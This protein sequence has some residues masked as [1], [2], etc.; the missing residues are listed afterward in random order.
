ML[1]SRRNPTIENRQ[2]ANHP[3]ITHLRFYTASARTRQS[4]P[5]GS[6]VCLVLAG[7][8]SRPLRSDPAPKRTP[9]HTSVCSASSKAS[10]TSMPRY[11][12]VSI[13]PPS[14]RRYRRWRPPRR[15]VRYPCNFHQILGRS[16]C[17]PSQKACLLS[18]CG[19]SRCGKKTEV[20]RGEY[21][22]SSPIPFLAG[23]LENASVLKEG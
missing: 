16:F 21:R 15:T 14:L 18:R 6:N 17:H 10:S 23:S 9:G 2:P 22:R 8:R 19:A 4:V 12:T 1:L 5:I 3:P 11:R 7:S 13:D 20:R